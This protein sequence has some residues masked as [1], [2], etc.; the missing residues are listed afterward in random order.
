MRRPFASP[1][2]PGAPPHAA[3]R[4]LG[5]PPLMGGGPLESPHGY[6]DDIGSGEQWNGVRYSTQPWQ[7]SPA[8][9][10]E[11]IDGDEKCT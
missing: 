9:W 1:V 4:G 10:S 2:T 5:A 3:P 7:Q 6:C 11:M 8:K